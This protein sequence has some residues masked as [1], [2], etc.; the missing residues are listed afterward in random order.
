MQEV[1]K[2]FSNVDA[3]LLA[4]RRLKQDYFSVSIVLFPLFFSRS[5]F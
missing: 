1:T 2:T 3:D 5:I 4:I